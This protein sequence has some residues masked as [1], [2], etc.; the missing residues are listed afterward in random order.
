MC[1][2]WE[3]VVDKWQAH[4]QAME[5]A[6]HVWAAIPSGRDFGAAGRGGN[7]Y[8]YQLAFDD[9]A[10]GMAIEDLDG[11]FQRVNAVLCQ[12]VGYDQAELIDM[13]CSATDFARVAFQCR[14]FRP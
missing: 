10:I 6:S 14:L 12:M 1:R 8:R 2:Y 5:D 11:R 13:P 7:E 4:T 3:T 9:S